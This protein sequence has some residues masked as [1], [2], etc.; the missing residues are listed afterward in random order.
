MQVIV[1]VIVLVHLEKLFTNTVQELREENL[2]LELKTTVSEHTV[3]VGMIV[4]LN[5]RFASKQNYEANI[6][7][8]LALNERIIELKKDIIF[9]KDYK[10]ECMVILATLANRD[11]IDNSLQVMKWDRGHYTRYISFRSSKSNMRLGELHIN[12]LCNV[13]VKYKYI[14]NKEL[15]EK[16]T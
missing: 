14:E 1:E 3:K 10:Q 12:S 11:K 7:K 4:G 16:V 9:K 6:Y 8:K 2:S 15:S 5:L 13:P